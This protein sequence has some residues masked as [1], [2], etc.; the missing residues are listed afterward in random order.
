MEELNRTEEERE[1]K[2]ELSLDEPELNELGTAQ[3]IDI[4]TPTSTQPNLKGTEE[5]N[6]QYNGV[7]LSLGSSRY[8]VRFLCELGL[9][10]Y[11]QLKDKQESKGVSYV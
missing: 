2:K 3:G 6:L 7:S 10:F 8:D 5:F 4:P 9:E 1:E 11:N